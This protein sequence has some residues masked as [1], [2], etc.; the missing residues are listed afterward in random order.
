MLF[1]LSLDRYTIVPVG[2]LILR[3][4]WMG[5]RRRRRRRRR[6]VSPSVLFYFNSLTHL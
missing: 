3:L 6:M 5:R 2:S 1:D 4:R